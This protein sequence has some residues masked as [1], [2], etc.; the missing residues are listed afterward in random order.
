M[1]RVLITLLLFVVVVLEFN[2]LQ[3]VVHQQQLMEVDRILDLVHR[4]LSTP[5]VEVVEELKEAPLQDQK[6]PPLTE[7]VVLAVL[8][9]VPVVMLTVL[10]VAVLQLH[11]LVNLVML[12]VIRQQKVLHLLAEVVVP[13]LPDKI[14]DQM[15]MQD[16]V[17]RE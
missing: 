2:I 11:F 5:Q 8:A 6:F 10:V 15:I 14:I 1:L 9:V 7:Q 16:M 4:F 12:E 13:V 3:Q 17:V